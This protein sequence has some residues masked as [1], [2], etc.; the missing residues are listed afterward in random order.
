MRY[1]RQ[2][3]YYNLVYIEVIKTEYLRYFCLFI[4]FI[5]NFRVNFII[6][7]FYYTANLYF[8]Y[9]ENTIIQQKW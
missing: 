8:N 9:K 3:T 7:N 4:K 5:V 6:K 1:M 2:L